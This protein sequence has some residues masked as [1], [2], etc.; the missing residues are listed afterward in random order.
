MVFPF[1][2]ANSPKIVMP[3]KGIS[4][5][6]IFDAIRVKDKYGV[7]PEQI[8]DYKALTGDASDNYPG[9]AGVGFVIGE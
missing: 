8:I 6:M 4:E 2:I 5:V 3:I 7:L 1:A 9:V